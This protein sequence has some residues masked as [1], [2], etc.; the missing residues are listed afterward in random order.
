MTT[1]KIYVPKNGPMKVVVF[2]SGGGSSLKAMLEDENHENLYNVVGCYTN[3]EDATGR[4]LAENAGIPVVYKEIT[5]KAHDVEALESEY[6]E[7]LKLIE[8][9]DPDLIALSGFMRIITKP[10]LT[11]YKNRI[12]NV[13]PARL[14]IL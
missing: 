6:T 5:A 12:L 8:K 3:K 14:E 7:V 2:L 11:E 4:E 10:V 9:F 13:H 1:D